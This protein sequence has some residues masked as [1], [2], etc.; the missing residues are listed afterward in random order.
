MKH[1]P[2]IFLFVMVFSVGC[3][4][5]TDQESYTPPPSMDVSISYVNEDGED[6]LEPGLFQFFNIYYLQKNEETGEF[7]NDT[8]GTSKYSFY[9]DNES[10]KYALRI[11]PNRDFIDGESRTIIESPRDN[12]DTLRVKGRNEGRG[13]IAERIW[14]NGELVWETAP[15]PPRRYFT[16]TKSSL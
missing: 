13:S 4:T 5:T 8:V 2:Y 9:L 7:E 14:Y 12:F 3:I 11:F 1:L 16:I 15:N 6:L 10:D